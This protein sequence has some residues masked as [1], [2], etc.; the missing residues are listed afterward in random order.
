MKVLIPFKFDSS[1][2][3]K[4]NVRE[5]FNGKSLLDITI[6]NFLKYNHDI[7]LTCV[8]GPQTE[9]LIRR[10]KVNHIPLNNTSNNWSEVV[11][12]LSKTLVKSFGPHEPV[13]LWQCIT[14]LFW[15][16]NDIQEFLSFAQENLEKCESVV[17]VYRFA[18]YLVN[19][20]MQG[21]NF[22]PGSWHVPSQNLSESYYITPMGVSTPA[23]YSKYHY[24]YSPKSTMW[25]AKGPYID[26]DTEEE[27]KMAQVLY[28]EKLREMNE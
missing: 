1:R 16:Y 24:T 22:N 2:Y 20:K 15:L 5:F 18:D 12:D 21:I 25:I 10:Y 26:I 11:I 19:D 23:I 4:K 7:Y 14:P 3:P 27:M 9:E 6:E 8:D 17:P 13:C 28:R